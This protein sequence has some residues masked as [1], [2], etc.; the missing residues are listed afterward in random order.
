MGVHMC[1]MPTR[2]QLDV[3]F[4]ENIQNENY[5]SAL[6][7][8]VAQGDVRKDNF[9]DFLISP[10]RFLSR[11]DYSLLV[12]YGE[13]LEDVLVYGCYEYVNPNI[14]SKNFPRKLIGRHLLRPRLLQMPAPGTIELARQF[15]R[16]SGFFQPVIHDLAF[17]GAGYKNKQMQFRIVATGEK[18]VW[19]DPAGKRWIPYLGVKRGKHAPLRVLDLLPEETE[20]DEECRLFAVSA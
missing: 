1:A 16:V 15:V 11:K 18:L 19:T 9:L 17:F 2:D 14:N 8:L 3:F 12:D 13:K 20:L 5:I 4:R 7:Q 10:D 6:M